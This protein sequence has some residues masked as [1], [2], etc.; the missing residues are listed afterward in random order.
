MTTCCEHRHL[1]VELQS[2]LKLGLLKLACRDCGA[3]IGQAERGMS[4]ALGRAPFYLA[5]DL[6]LTAR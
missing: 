2:D 1:Q 5:K 4:D 3:L 6:Q